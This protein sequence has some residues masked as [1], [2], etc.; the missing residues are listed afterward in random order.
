MTYFTAIDRCLQNMSSVLCVF[1]HVIDQVK[2]DIPGLTTLSIRGDNAGCYSG[3]AAIIARQVICAS[4]DIYLKRADFSEPQRGNDQADRDIA[5]A[6][7]CLKAYTN[8]G[9]NLINAKSIKE[10]L[11]ESFGN[12]SGCKTSVIAVDESKCYLPNMKIEGITKYHSVAFND[13]SITLWQYFDIGS[14]KSKNLTDCK[15]IL[16][17]TVILPFSDN[18]KTNKE[19]LMK[20]TLSSAI[21]FCSVDSCAATFDNEEELMNHE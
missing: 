10:A 16:H 13:K 1:E 20:S 11:V 14:G 17:T 5:V 18:Q 9:G 6:T 4:A 21:F 15:C 3:T 2:Q 19:I 8:R 12:L 7:S